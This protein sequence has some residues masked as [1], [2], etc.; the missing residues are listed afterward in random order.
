[1][2]DRRVYD[3]AHREDPLS[4]TIFVVVDVLVRIWAL[5]ESRAHLNA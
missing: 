5:W 4:A 3:S 2:N 1:M